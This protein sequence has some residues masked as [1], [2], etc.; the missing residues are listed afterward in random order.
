MELQFELC[1]PMQLYVSSRSL[2]RLQRVFAFL[3]K[4]HRARWALS[5]M[6]HAMQ[7]DADA[8]GVPGVRAWWVLRADL[9]HVVGQLL[10]YLTTAMVHVEW[11]AFISRLP[12][13]RDLDSYMSA[14][15]DFAA[16][17]AAR[18]M[19]E[20]R[21]APVTH[22]VH[23]I[24]SLALQLRIH[25]DTLTPESAAHAPTIERWRVELRHRVQSMLD[26]LR[27]GMVEQGGRVDAD[28]LELCRAL[29][30][31]HPARQ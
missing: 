29:D 31:R 23:Q 9:L 6:H 17:V 10:G 5:S 19:L 22:A 3:L 27:R 15:D 28:L 18:C 1:W 12:A 13:L 14:H 7:P 20:P 4:L 8:D 21:H 16:R 24:L 11:T 25:V 26:A 30:V 2:T